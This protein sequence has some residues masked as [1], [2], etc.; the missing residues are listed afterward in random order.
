MRYLGRVTL[1]ILALN[2][3]NIRADE[4]A[5][6]SLKILRKTISVSHALSSPVDTVEDETSESGVETTSNINL[7]GKK[8]ELIKNQVKYRVNEDEG[9][10]YDNKFYVKGKRV[11]AESFVDGDGSYKYVV[12]IPYTEIAGDLFSYSFYGI[13]LGVNAGMSYEG[14]L[15]AGV[16]SE[17]LRHKPN[18]NTDM[19]LIK[20]SA[21]ADLM[22]RAFIEGQ[23]KILFIKGGVGGAINLID[24]ESQIS[25]GVT[26]MSINRPEVAYS[27]MVDILSGSLYGYV[28]SG[29]TRRL[30]HDIYKH[31]GFC[32]AFGESACQQN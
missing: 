17:L 19:D 5:E 30:A 21:S 28:G 2:C 7:F 32:F 31:K 24:G 9:V 29:S 10:S 14:M 26:P 12:E 8:I 18:I 16:S 23:V 25:I 11:L 4:L 1:C 3:Q 20:A 15:S 13:T 27:G 22:A 6:K